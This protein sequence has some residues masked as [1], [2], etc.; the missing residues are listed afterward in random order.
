MRR[1]IFFFDKLT[2]WW[3]ILGKLEK[4]TDISSADL[5]AVGAIL[6]CLQGHCH[7]DWSPHIHS[8]APP[9]NQMSP[10]SNLSDSS[11]R[12]PKK[13]IDSFHCTQNESQ[14][15]LTRFCRTRPLAT[16]PPTMAPSLL[17]QHPAFLSI[18]AANLQIPL[19]FLLSALPHAIPFAWNAFPLFTCFRS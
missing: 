12:K 8:G 1:R 3:S 7:C 15:G 5:D 13:H 17:S 16:L 11:G 18:L 19:L 10:H 9:T 14:R 6:F 2:I 4:G